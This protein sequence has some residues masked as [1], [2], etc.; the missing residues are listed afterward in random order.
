M[1]SAIIPTLQKSKQTLFNLLKMLLKDEKIGEIIVIDN[2]LLGIDFNDKK[3]KI[4]TPEQNL[5]VNPSWNLGVKEAKYNKIALLNDDISI[6]ENFCAR[7]SPFLAENE[8]IFGM[9]DDYV[10]EVE[11]IVD[12]PEQTEIK[13]KKIKCRQNAFGVAMFFNKASYFEIPDE[14]KIVY[15]DDWLFLKN[16]KLKKQNYIIEGQTIFHLGSLSSGEKCFNPICGSDAKIFKKLTVK[17]Y[18]RLFSFQEWYDSYK[19]RLFG[20]TYKI[21][22]RNK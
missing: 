21:L 8:G 14:I 19:L 16:K 5:Y 20:I 9:S 12:T 2:S 11:K 15:G 7:I 22:K 13:I 4:I 18:H 6:P 1:I 17:W 3:I 10:K